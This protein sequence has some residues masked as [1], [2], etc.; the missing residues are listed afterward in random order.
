MVTV[1][2]SAEAYRAL[3]VGAEGFCETCGVLLRI[4][5]A[6]DVQAL[7]L[8]DAALNSVPF[9]E[10]RCPNCEEAAMI[11]YRGLKWS[12]RLV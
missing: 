9:A 12:E 1:I 7:R 11:P 6:V 3:F 4:D 8:P 5:A 10:V 2:S